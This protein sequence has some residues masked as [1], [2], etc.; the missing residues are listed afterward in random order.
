[1]FFIGDDFY[2]Q[3]VCLR[4]NGREIDARDLLF[5]KFQSCTNHLKPEKKS[6]E[7]FSP[8]QIGGQ[9]P[10]KRNHHQDLK[11][12]QRSQQNSFKKKDAFP[13]LHSFMGNFWSPIG[14]D[15]WSNHGGRW[16]FDAETKI[17]QRLKKQPAVWMSD[18]VI[19]AAPKLAKLVKA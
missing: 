3:K 9:N 2:Y 15:S 19:A 16:V 11:T 17:S 14:A 6:D 13:P 12:A 18:E 10:P 8:F 4:E 7:D 1:M 5:L